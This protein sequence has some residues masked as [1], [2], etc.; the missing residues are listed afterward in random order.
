MIRARTCVAMLLAGGEGRRLGVLTRETAKPAVPFGGKYRIIDFALS[1]CSNS[2]VETVGVLTQYRPLVLNSHIGVGAPWGLDK[3]QGGLCLLPPFVGDSGGTWYK[4]TANAIYQ[5]LNIIEEY[6]PEYVLVLSGDH[7]YKMDYSHMLHF[8]KEA[9][10]DL[11]IACTGVP[12][13]EAS[14]FGVVIKDASS[15]IQRFQEKPARPE[16]NLASMGVYIFNT[17]PLLEYLKRDNADASSNN[18]FGK[19]VI[20]KML[21]EGLRLYSHTFGG[22]WKD[23]G[24]VESLWEAN[25]DLLGENPDMDLHDESWPV[26]TVNHNLPPHYIAKSANVS[27]SLISEGCQI[28]G[29]VEHSVIFPGVVIGKRSVIKDAVI[30]SGTLIGSDVTIERAIIGERCRVGDCCSTLPD[31]LGHRGIVVLRDRST[32]ASGQNIPAVSA[33]PVVPQAQSLASVAS[34][35]VGNE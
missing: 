6:N 25:M 32:L 19:D 28:F 1:N 34:K 4:G 5:N 17:K 27:R 29:S 13:S 23:V 10:A 22:Y 9:G 3:K 12:W 2:G 7:I 30:M 24:T 11:T 33:V 31:P 18:D 8:H 14:R 26:F 15:R 21:A 20:P 16:S 35:A